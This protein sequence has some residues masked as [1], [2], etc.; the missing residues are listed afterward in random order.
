M[1]SSVLQMPR[2]MVYALPDI[3]D[4]SYA[5]VLPIEKP[6]TGAPTTTTPA[7]TT[8]TQIS[9]PAPSILRGK[10]LE[11]IVNK[12]TAELE[13]HVK[14]FGQYAGEVAV[15]DRALVESGNNVCPSVPCELTDEVNSPRSSINSSQLFTPPSLLLSVNKTTLTNRWN[16]SNNSNEIW[17]LLLMPTRKSQ[18][19][20]W[21]HR[22]PLHKVA[23]VAYDLWTLVLLIQSETASTCFIF[24]E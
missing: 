7:A 2:K 21:A 20:F 22:S 14:E 5:D 1:V 19:K 23:Q 13:T 24:H 6:A 16:I 8:S 15:W 4:C 17:R 9:V 11:E 12:W 18:M 3:S 10:T